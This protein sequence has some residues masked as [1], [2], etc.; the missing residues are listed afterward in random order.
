MNLDYKKQV[1]AD[2]SDDSR[3]WIFQADRPFNNEETE[4]IKRELTDFN[5][6][7]AAH[8]V[9]LFSFADLWFNRFIVL[10][11]DGS[12]VKICGGS[13]DDSTRFMKKLEKEHSVKLLDRHLLAFVINGDVEVV[14][15]NGIDAL[16]KEGKITSDTLY[17]N[18]TIITKDD[19][20][21]RWVL[22]IK[23]S[24]LAKR[25]PQLSAVL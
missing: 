9:R 25:L 4:S 8:G 23:E 16:V 17:F 14:S 1:P 19:L 12:V 24:W 20:L 10:M 22:P 11:A 5:N 6:Q 18:N 13:T 21:N 15:M 2:F 7:W 3:V